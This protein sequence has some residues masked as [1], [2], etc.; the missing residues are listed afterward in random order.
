MIGAAPAFGTP[1]TKG[2]YGGIE[3]SASKRR[4]VVNF[5]TVL[6]K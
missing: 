6:G 5:L 2:G 3:S 4:I 1:I